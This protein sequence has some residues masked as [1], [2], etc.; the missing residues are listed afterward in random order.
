M[1]FQ[2]IYSL[3]NGLKMTVSLIYGAMMERQL[4]RY[5][6]ET[7]NLNGDLQA[8]PFLR[9]DEWRRV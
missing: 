2:A 4:Y 8:L 3:G 5:A 7:G 1:S 6:C 9:A